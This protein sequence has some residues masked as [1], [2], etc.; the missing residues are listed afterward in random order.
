M[1]SPVTVEYGSAGGKAFP[2][3]AYTARLAGAGFEP[4]MSNAEIIS[5]LQDLQAESVNVVVAKGTMRGDHL[6]PAVLEP[7]IEK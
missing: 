6:L 5:R 4:W 3:W 7:A 2:D 1:I